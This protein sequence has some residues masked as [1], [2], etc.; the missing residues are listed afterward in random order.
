M[1]KAEKSTETMFDKLYEGAKETIK[2]M[3]K[4][5]AKRALKRKLMAARDAAL[6][7]IDQSN[8]KIQEEVQKISDCDV[9]KVLKYK[10]DIR[11]RNENIEDTE[12]LYKELFN[13]DMPKDI[14]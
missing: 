5:L 2:A 11:S 12:S 1:A 6:N 7:E 9:N 4:P 8:L 3:Q 13:E 10:F 14:D